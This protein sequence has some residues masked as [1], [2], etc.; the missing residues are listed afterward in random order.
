MGHGDDDGKK[1]DAEPEHVR[2]SIG[3][4]AHFVDDKVGIDPLVA[5]NEGGGGGVRVAV[6]IVGCARGVCGLC[7]AGASCERGTV[8]LDDRRGLRRVHVAER[9]W[10]RSASGAH[11]AVVDLRDT[12]DVDMMVVVTGRGRTCSGVVFV[13]S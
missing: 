12:E 10:G 11:D 5:V 8:A 2:V 9:H 4:G 1:G 3:G 7:A 13:S 6:R